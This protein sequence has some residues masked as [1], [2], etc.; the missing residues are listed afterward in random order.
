MKL[1]PLALVVAVLPVIFS[2]TR[3]AG[4]EQPSQTRA[5]LVEITLRATGES[6]AD[7]KATLEFPSVKWQDS[8]QIAVFDGTAKNIFSIPDGGNHGTSATFSGTVT[9]G[10]AELYA[11]SPPSAGTSLAGSLLT[12]NIPSV[13]SIPAGLTAAPE[14][15]VC[16]AKAQ[17]GALQFRNVVSLIKISISA[18]NVTSAII[19]GTNLSGT[20]RVNSDGTLAQPLKTSGTI[21]LKPSAATFTPGDYYAAVLPG[22]TPPGGF[23]IALIR[24]DGLSCTLT[25]TRTQTF[26][27]N[28]CKSVGDISSAAAWSNIIYTKTQLFTWNDTRNP[29]DASD[30]PILGADI[31]ME[32]TPWTPKNFAGTFDG[33]GHKLYNINVSTN[34]Y[35]GFLRELT[36]GASVKDL[37]VGS[38]DGVIYDGQSIIKHSKSA[39][40]YT[41]Y[42]AGAIAKVSGTSTVSN[43]TNFAT[44]EVASDATGKTR[45]GGIVGNW[46]STG[47]IKSCTNY[48]AVRNN[49]A[50]TGQASQSDAT[51]NGSLVG[52]VLGFFDVR[53]TIDD[54]SNYGSVTTVN[55]GVTAIGGVVGYDGRGSTV[56]DCTNGGQVKH[57]AKTL[58]SDTAVGG[59]IAYAQGTSS[60]YGSVRTCSNGGAVSAG[61]N[62]KI[63][64]VGGVSGYTDYYNV[65]GCSNSG[66]IG[67]SNSSATT[68]YIA[69]AGICAHTYHGCII[70][71]CTNQ[72]PVSSDKPQVN[73]VGGIVGT[74]NSSAARNCTN[75]GSVT[76]DNS[77]KV[78]TNWESVGGIAGFAEGETGIREITGCTNEGSVTAVVNTTGRDTPGRVAAGGIVGSP[79]TAYAV[80]NNINKGDVSLQNKHASTPY[81]YAG[82]IFGFDAASTSGSSVASNHNYG[83]VGIISGKAGYSGAGGLFGTISNATPITDNRNYGSVSGAVA[84]GVAGINAC[85][86]KAVVCDAATVNGV[87]YPDASDKAA[88]A[89]PSS[90]GSITVVVT[91]HSD[92]EAD[93][94]EDEAPKPLDPGNKVV[95]H[96]GGAT[97]CG[98][99]DNSR[100]ALRYAMNLG[101]Y[102]SECD[103]YWTSDND[104]I[105]AH[106]DS[107]DQVNGMNPWEHTAAEIIA[108]KRLSNYERIPTLSEYIDIVME[109]GSKTKLLLDIKMIDN[110]SVDYDHPAKAALRAIEI[111]QE[112]NAQNFCEFI[113]T[114]Y[115]GVM[116]RIAPA[117]KASGI[118]CGWMNG[119]ISASTFKSKGYT[120]WANLNTRDHFKL[121]SGEDQGTGYRTITEYKNAGLQLSVFHIDKQSGNSSAVYTDATV[122]LYLDEYQYLRCITTNYPAWLLQKTKDL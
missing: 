25:S 112:K 60:T 77:A 8:D 95:A 85:E 67:Y 19:S 51:P 97:E 56:K 88:W 106:A 44:V 54:C 79:H 121:G 111:I 86:F 22:S 110:P 116:S 99:P 89:C 101:C 93:P 102:A 49:A 48:G 12:V 108:A 118:P 58:V 36:G 57:Q 63:I 103:I 55:P 35:A 65:S 41:W 14:A 70:S 42:Y 38:S 90:T 1:Q 68:Q 62:D 78:I 33:R 59:V 37:V 117:I 82:G 13:Q 64:R 15:L 69:I 75:K 50:T 30:A 72:G 91:P 7:S 9:E 114:S 61:G 5:D 104:V 18:E 84:G 53:S 74:L 34:N 80:T 24:S 47:T 100:A 32:M 39:N 11:V 43:V 115:E 94:V 40:N 83:A 16:V 27:R 3:E 29:S 98:Y 17:Q 107:K 10:A 28:G 66:A 45:T 46:N 2:C 73:R 96:R 105:V 71:S 6:P 87:T 113:C 109:T 4:M 21:E 23:S 81:A 76:L 52:G 119:S 120:D 122:Q 31:D 92:P 26:T 20:A